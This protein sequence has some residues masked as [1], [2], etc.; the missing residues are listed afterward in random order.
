[1]NVGDQVKV[2]YTGDVHGPYWKI[3]ILCQRLQRDDGWFVEIENHP[4]QWAVMYENIILYYE[5]VSPKWMIK[6]LIN[7][8]AYR[9]CYCIRC[10][11]IRKGM[12]FATR[13]NTKLWNLRMEHRASKNARSA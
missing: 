13:M 12:P 11:L 2:R 10:G 3:G 5:A 1:M 7:H 6:L 8:N 9:P 4:G